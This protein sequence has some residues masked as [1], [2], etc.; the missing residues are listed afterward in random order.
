M[1]TGYDTCSCGLHQMFYR[2]FGNRIQ[3]R[4]GGFII[5]I[6]FSVAVVVAVALEV[7]DTVA[8]AVSIAIAVAIAL[9]V[10][11]L[12]SIPLLKLYHKTPIEN[13][14]EEDQFEDENWA[15]ATE[16]DLNSNQY[17]LDS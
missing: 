7:T 17:E 9:A 14:K 12:S 5:K 15:R 11:L 2:I 10:A 16:D 8:V 13:K 4:C 3:N 6:A 1:Y